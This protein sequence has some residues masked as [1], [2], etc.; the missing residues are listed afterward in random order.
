MAVYQSSWNP[1]GAAAQQRHSA[2]LARIE[3]LR[4]LEER[5]AALSERS[6]PVFDRRG[7][8][9]PR[10]RLGLLLDPGAPYLP[11]CSLAGYLKDSDDPAASVPGGGVIAGIGFVS[12]VRCAL[13]ASDSGIDA[14][15]LQPM[16]LEKMLRVQEIALENK[17]PFIH[18]VESAGANLLRYR[19]ENFVQGG[20]LF[21]NL[22]RLSAAGIPVVTVQHGSGTAGGGLPAGIERP[23]RDGA[24]AVA[25]LSGR[26]ALVDGGHG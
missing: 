13:V 6:R 18:L 23:G 11:L 3:Q 17:L 7:Q 1:H 10:E 2:M 12:G 15:A 8:L 25:G 24:Q 16:G 21:R 19:V 9:L 4:G 20:A 26:A 5:A 22:A 14:G